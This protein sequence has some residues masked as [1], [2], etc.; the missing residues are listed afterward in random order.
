M[1]RFML[2]RTFAITHSRTAVSSCVVVSNVQTTVVLKDTFLQNRIT[3]S[4]IL[5]IW[6]AFSI[7]TN[8]F[9]E[10]LNQFIFP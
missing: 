8:G 10:R 3:G 6:E 9:P 7:L 2:D 5:N 1:L 4:E